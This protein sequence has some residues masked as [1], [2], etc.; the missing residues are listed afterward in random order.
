MSGER[1]PTEEGLPMSS[2]EDE[3]DYGGV[4]YGGVDYGGVD[5]G[6]VDYGGGDPGTVPVHKVDK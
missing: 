4:N 6:G 1:L 3:F 2:D 5:Y